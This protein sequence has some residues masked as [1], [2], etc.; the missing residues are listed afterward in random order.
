MIINL[1]NNKMTFFTN[2]WVFNVQGF[3]KFLKLWPPEMCDC[4]E[5][6]KQ[7]FPSYLLEMAFADI[8]ESKI[9][10]INRASRGNSKCN[11]GYLFQMARVYYYI[12]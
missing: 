9:F 6:R 7:T 1:I 3:Q 5:P 11:E 4:F 2:L 12:L 10:R 8:L